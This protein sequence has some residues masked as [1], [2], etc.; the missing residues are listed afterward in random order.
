MHAAVMPP[1]TAEQKL[2]GQ[3]KDEEA[4]CAV[5]RMCGGKVINVILARS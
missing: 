5:F 1:L 3:S 2:V 4:V